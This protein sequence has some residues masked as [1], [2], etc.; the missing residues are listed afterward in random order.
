[1]GIRRT[2]RLDIIPKTWHPEFSA[3]SGIP[4]QY[5]LVNQFPA[6]RRESHHKDR[7]RTFIGKTIALLPKDCW[8]SRV[9]GSSLKTLGY[10]LRQQQTIAYY[11][12]V[13]VN[14]KMQSCFARIP[15]EPFTHIEGTPFD[16]AVAYYR[17]DAG[18]K[19]RRFVVIRKLV[20]VRTKANTRNH[21]LS[22][23]LRMSTSRLLPMPMTMRPKRKSFVPTIQAV[24]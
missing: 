5:G 12:K 9:R 24:R 13:M 4:V 21:S 7:L 16:L 10:S 3:Q 8:L 18:G 6:L 19:E 23:R 2:Q 14:P 11:L 17:P 20:P 1:M 22:Y 15:E